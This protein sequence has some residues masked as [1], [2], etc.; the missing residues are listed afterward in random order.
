VKVSSARRQLGRLARE[1]HKPPPIRTVPD[2]RPSIFARAGFM[3]H[4]RPKP[5][6]TAQAES[7]APAR[8]TETTHIAANCGPAAKRGSMNCGKRR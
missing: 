2:S 1:S 6:A 5:D 3:N 8:T 7:D 4:A